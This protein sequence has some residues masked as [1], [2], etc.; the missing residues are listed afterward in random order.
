MGRDLN[1][2]YNQPPG[3]PIYLGA[4]KPLLRLFYNLE[5]IVGR[6]LATNAGDFHHRLRTTCEIM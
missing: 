6:T 2:E 3:N 1:R 4:K 5:N